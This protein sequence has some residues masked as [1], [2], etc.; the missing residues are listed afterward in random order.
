VSLFRP[1]RVYAS[2]ELDRISLVR[3]VG[4]RS[5]QVEEERV[6][7]GAS[8][9]DQPDGAIP[10][11][12]RA[13]AEPGWRATPRHV[14]VSDRLV[15]YLV[16]AR[17]QGV[18]TAAELRLLI[19]SRYEALLDSPAAEWAI[20]A[21]LRPLARHFVACAMPRRLVEALEKAFSVE[22][23]CV[24]LRPFLI[25][26]LKR[27]AGRL[28]RE[29]WY[30]VAA[31]DSLTLARISGGE[32]RRLRVLPAGLSSAAHI[33]DL[34]DRE[35]LTAG[36][37]GATRL[38]ASGL[39]EGAAGTEQVTQLDRRAWPGKPKAWARSYRLALSEVWT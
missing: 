25:S 8:D 29:C 37:K 13:M 16:T 27:R 24:S 17:P 14:V 19:E 33:S 20:A 11:L 23:T 9:P 31:R 15:H 12:A 4:Y 1:R 6:I 26:E 36:D 30:A 32:C 21:D 3:L 10:E 22:G 2:V 34:V 39:I 5:G 18:Q 28:P 35:R 7:E 38:L